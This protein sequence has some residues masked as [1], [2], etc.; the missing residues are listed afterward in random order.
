MKKTKWLLIIALCHVI[1][2]MKGQTLELALSKEGA[3]SGETVFVKM[4]AGEN[5]S[6]ITTLQFSLAWDPTIINYQGFTGEALQGVALGDSDA[7]QGIARLSWFAAQGMGIDLAPGTVLIQLEYTAIGQNGDS[8]SVA[9]TDSPL[10]IQIAQETDTTG[11]FNILDLEQDTGLVKIG[12]FLNFTA[13][14]SDVSCTGDN[15]GAVVLNFPDGA[16]EY[17]FSWEGTN[18]SSTEKDIANLAPGN[19]TVSISDQEGSIVLVETYSIGEP[20]PLELVNFSISP[21][22]C[23]QENGGIA[24]EVAG[25]TRPYSFDYGQGNTPDS[26]RNDLVAGTY[27]III[28]DDNSCNINADLEIPEQVAPEVDLGG[29]VAICIGGTTMLSAGEHTS[30]NWSTGANGPTINVSTPGTYS[31][32]VTNDLGCEGSD[33]VEVSIGE[34]LQL[35]LLNPFLDVCPSEYIQLQVQGAPNYEWIDT[36]GTLSSLG[37]SNP[38]ARPNFT[39][40]YTVIGSNECASDT[41]TVEVVV[42][43][44]DAVAGPDTCI[45]PGTDAILYALGGIAYEW[46]ESDYPVLDPTAQETTASPEEATSYIVSITDVNGCVVTDTMEVLVAADPVES[47]RRINLITPN[48]DGM[49]DAL[50]FRGVEKFG[51]NKLEVYNRWGSLVYQKVNYQLDDERFDGTKNGQRLPAGNYYYVLSFT[52]GDIRQKLM[53]VRD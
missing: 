36:S 3:Q 33:A 30:Y 6:R 28:S 51:P 10:R 7:D 27:Q 43:E 37:I 45:A 46:Q 13:L 53:I 5:F 38:D 29:N 22:D 19:Y 49:N 31:V 16:N 2:A 17:S 18:F 50:E 9:I 12:S 15:D 14:P 35:E 11:M 32:T 1:G 47:I 21:P 23:N 42:N 44:T 34:S 26:A 52:T 20:D 24:L 8:S 39:T 41:L 40:T 25:G 48:D 4:L